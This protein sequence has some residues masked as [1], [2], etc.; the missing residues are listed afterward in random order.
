MK[1]E[2][3]A[4]YVASLQA[5][6]LS[7]LDAAAAVR[8]VSS[9]SARVLDLGSALLLEADMPASVE[10]LEPEETSVDGR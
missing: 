9:L 2:T 7:S 4:D 10:F 8:V 5:I 6:M 3:G 1:V